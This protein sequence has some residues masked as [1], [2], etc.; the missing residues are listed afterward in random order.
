MKLYFVTA[1]VVSALGAAAWLGRVGRAQEHDP[2]H[3][4]H[5][6][7]GRVKLNDQRRAAAG[8]EVV[9]C[10]RRTLPEVVHTTG[11]IEVNADRVAHLGSRLPGIVLEVT[12][13]GFLGTRVEEGDALAIVHSIDFG[14][15]QMEYR[16]A[17]QIVDLRQKTFDREKGLYERKVSSGREF[18]ES[19]TELAQAQ[20]DLQ[21]ARNQLEVLGVGK[22]EIDQL[23]SGKVPSGCMTLR[24]TLR[25]VI[26]EK[27]VVK[28]EHV[29]MESSLFTI[30][31]VERLWV[32]ADIYERDLSRVRNGQAAQIYIAAHTGTPFPAT[33]TYVPETMNVETRTLQVR[34]EV[35][36]KDGRLKPGMFVEVDLAVSE[37]ADVL[38]VPESAV[39]VLRSRPIVFV[40]EEPNVFELRVVRTGVRFGGYVEILEGLD[41]K[42]KV[43]TSGSFLLKSEMEKEGFEAGHGH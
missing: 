4:E 43:V 5:G 1:V 25:G 2:K 34:I 13:K 7:E 14:K 28:G 20:I 3:E 6:D 15:A 18:I 16:K 8:I 22:E 9:A 32:F 41:E 26:I 37:R 27:H 39:Q 38:A 36:N 19:E 42:D 10:E 11:T 35:Q 24:S 29:D 40:E 33:V 31:D 17:L 12:P 23:P 30:A 21:T